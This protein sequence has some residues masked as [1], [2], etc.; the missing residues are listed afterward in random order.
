L[1]RIA[2]SKTITIGRLGRFRFPAGLY[3]YTGSAKRNLEARIRRHLS[4]ANRLR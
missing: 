4:R 3:T 2:R 1:I